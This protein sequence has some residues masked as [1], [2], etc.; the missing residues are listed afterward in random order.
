MRKASA[1]LKKYQAG[2]AS[3]EEKAIV[4]SWYLKYETRKSDLTADELVKEQELGLRQLQQRIQKRETSVVR[5]RLVAAAAVVV[6]VLG[7]L[8]YFQDTPQ[9]IQTVHQP[10][11]TALDIIPGGNKAIL[12]L[13]NG[14]KIS[15]TD[16]AVGEI[17][18]GAD[19]Y[20]EKTKDGQLVYTAKGK[21]EG[22][23]K[24]Y[25]SIQTPVGGEYQVNLPDGSKVWLNAT[26]TLRFPTQFGDRERR[27]ELLGE[28][29]FEITKEAHGN[30]RVPF[31]VVSNGQEVRV[32][33]TVFN[34][35]AYPDD[36]QT[37]TTLLN[38]LVKVSSLDSG[39]MARSVL[40]KPGQKAIK[41]GKEIAVS[42]ADI[43]EEM[44]WKKGYFVFNN[45]NIKVIMKKLERWYDMDVVYQGDMSDV[46]FQGNYSRERS[47]SNLL[48]SIA[49]TNQVKF[50]IEGRRVFVLKQPTE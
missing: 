11:R 4:E 49:L 29:Y 2:V 39:V 23:P 47:L 10:K 45:E 17:F 38:G 7:S 44:A 31:T 6:L 26:S 37:R 30:R 34:I 13:A 5:F 33:G 46:A 27:V 15:L 20:I 22:E 50:K 3:E 48:K 35:S 36:N 21:A 32:L 14:R 1:L 8:F 18:Q 9:N 12:T 41:R 42:D 19:V 40:L 16:V 24:G 25:H 43:Y 28:A